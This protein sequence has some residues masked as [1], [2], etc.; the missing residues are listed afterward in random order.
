MSYIKETF[1]F[2]K[3]CPFLF[4][5]TNSRQE[6]IHS[7][8]CL[9]LNYI[10]DG[11]GH[12]LIEDKTYPI[13]PGDIFVINNMEHHMAIHKSN[14]K[15]FVFVFDQ[16]LVW[17]LADEYDYLKPF[18]ERNKSFSN[19]INQASDKY[20][21][22]KDSI[23]HIKD[24][25]EL[26]SHGWELM[27]KAWLMVTLA[28]LNR[29]YNEQNA[30][31]TIVQANS[32]QRIRKVVEY[33]HENFAEEISLSKLSEVALMTKTYLSAYFSNVMHMRVFDYVELVRVTHAK[34]LLKT[35]DLSILEI[36]FQS[37]FK[38]SSYFS[39]VFKKIM[40]ITPNEYRKNER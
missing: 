7:H 11:T 17:D 33:I 25:Y 2:S 14:L 28:L 38:S 16:N 27:T 20:V 8:D 39:R 19:K 4:Y 22:I 40:N 12:Y 9:E 18:F 36:A 6:M 31:D 29:Y 32:Y 10:V 34:L 30:L 5:E 13:E 24:E 1:N 15:M 35:T 21:L 3:Q 37:G 26:Q 23:L